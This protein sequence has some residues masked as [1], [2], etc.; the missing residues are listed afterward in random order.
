MLIKHTSWF[1]AQYGSLSMWSCQGLEYSHK[2]AKSAY[3][4]YA[5][6]SGGKTKTKKNP[7]LQTYEHWY[8]II[9]DRFR[10]QKIQDTVDD[11]DLE[12]E[13]QIEARREMSL[14]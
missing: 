2:A 6:H 3:Q 4:R 5:Q 13:A 7:I 9:Q 10:K 8:Q 1:V 12:L 11:Q 14:A